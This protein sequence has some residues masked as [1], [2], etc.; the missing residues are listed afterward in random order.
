MYDKLENELKQVISTE[1]KIL[2]RYITDSS[3]SA[4]S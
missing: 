1:D 2:H 3:V 4:E